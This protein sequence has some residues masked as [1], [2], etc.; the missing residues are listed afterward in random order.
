M[1]KSEASQMM[2]VGKSVSKTFNTGAEHKRRLIVSNAF[3]CAEVHAK[4]TF[5]RVND[6][7]GRAISENLNINFR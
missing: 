7:S 4:I 6:V 5:L 1:A 2:R 3:Y